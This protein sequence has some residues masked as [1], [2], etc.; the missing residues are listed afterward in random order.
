MKKVS[1]PGGHNGANGQSESSATLRYAE[2]RA[3]KTLAQAEKA[4]IELAATRRDMIPRGQV[5]SFISRSG[6][7]LKAR[8]LRMVNDCSTSLLG[9]DSAQINDVLLEKVRHALDVAELQKEFLESGKSYGERT[10]S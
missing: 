6:N 9:L 2:A 10:N 8:L 5:E 3:R 4:E 7:I 1:A